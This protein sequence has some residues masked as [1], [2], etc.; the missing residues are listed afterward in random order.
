MFLITNCQDYEFINI[1]N[2]FLFSIVAVLIIVICIIDLIKKPEINASFGFRTKASMSCPEAW[3]L[4]NTIGFIF[5]TVLSFIFLILN[6]VFTLLAYYCLIPYFV[7]YI[8]LGIYM[9][10]LV[11]LVIAVDIFIRIKFRSKLKQN[12]T[13]CE[14]IENE[15]SKKQD[16]DDFWN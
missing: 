7:A 9:I 1:F 13:K 4:A 3:K 8:N 2:L 5:I 14:L 16:I 6:I 10:S 12:K 15:K 11:V